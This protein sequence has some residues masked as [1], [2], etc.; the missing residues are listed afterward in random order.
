MAEKTNY[1]ENITALIAK[2]RDKGLA[3]YGETL[4]DNTTLSRVQRIEHLEEE[5]VDALMYAEHIKAVVEDGLTANDYQR[6]AMRTASGMASEETVAE[7]ALLVNG[8][9]GLNGEAGE[10][11]DIV[12]K[13]LFQGHELEREHLIEELG[14]CAWYLAV[15]CE[16]LGVSLG[17]CMRRNIDKLSARYPEGFDKARSINRNGEKTY[18]LE[19]MKA[20]LGLDAETEKVAHRKT[21]LEDLL[22]RLPGAQM[23]GVHPLACRAELYGNCECT[24]LSSCEI[25]WK[26]VMPE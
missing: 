10:C 9:M 5:L 21:Y 4:E 15:S 12:K 25:C 3:K 17:E 7:N 1:A 14:D 18:T 16:A 22:E 24:E 19:E 6:M 2:Q 20:E 11:I 8:V 13:H 26:E 23:N